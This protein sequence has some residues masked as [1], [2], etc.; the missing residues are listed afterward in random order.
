MSGDTE[1]HA[2]DWC[3]KEHALDRWEREVP[4]YE[5]SHDVAEHWADPKSTARV[6]KSD[7]V[8]ELRA[9]LS[10]C[11]KSLADQAL[12]FIAAMQDHGVSFSDLPKAM[13]TL[14]P[15]NSLG[16]EWIKSDRRLGL[17]IEVDPTNSSW[18]YVSKR[19]AGG[20]HV[21]GT[22]TDPL[23]ASAF[24]WFRAETGRS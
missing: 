17:G 11:E 2:L 24:A 7:A 12:S 9:Q 15:G 20:R 18:F 1:A 19:T 5:R 10:K 14:E 22:L 16:I 3:S 8:E 4:T 13:V 23:A 21:A 6:V